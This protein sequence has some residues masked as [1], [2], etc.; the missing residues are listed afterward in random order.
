MKKIM[1]IL[2]A[3]LL[4]IVL[5][6]CGDDETSG[7][8]DNTENNTPQT[9]ENKQD[10]GEVEDESDTADKEKEEK[11]AGD[12]AKAKEVFDKAAEANKDL[13][14]FHVVMDMVQNMESDDGESFDS[15]SAIDMDIV[16]EPL[17]MKQVMTMDLGELG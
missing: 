16:Q 15:V 11:P 12:N 7:E 14:S 6:A 10:D 2:F 1:H 8:T 3:A 5:A 17:S 9:E 4:V 13:N